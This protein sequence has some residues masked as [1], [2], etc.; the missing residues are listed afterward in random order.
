[1]VVADE[2]AEVRSF[3]I[4]KEGR[5]GAVDVERSRAHD[6]VKL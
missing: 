3:D 1:L 2:P 4:D 5:E 6:L